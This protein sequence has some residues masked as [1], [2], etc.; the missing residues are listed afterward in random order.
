MQ[1]SRW[2]N[3]P[4]AFLTSA[5][6][7]IINAA[8]ALAHVFTLNFSQPST[9]PLPTCREQLKDR[10]RFIVVSL[11]QRL[12]VFLPTLEG[13]LLLLLPRDAENTDDLVQE[14]V[15]SVMKVS[16]ACGNFVQKRALMVQFLGMSMDQSCMCW[17]HVQFSVARQPGCR[18]LTA[19]DV[20]R[21]CTCQLQPAA[22]L[23]APVPVAGERGMRQC[24][25]WR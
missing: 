18:T 19:G 6:H 10:Q 25:N 20:H 2:P 16:G 1:R 21:L 24:D 12:L 23:P 22:A 3:C 17:L 4:P 5:H 11:G 7:H 13:E 15:Q 14:V 8:K 9:H